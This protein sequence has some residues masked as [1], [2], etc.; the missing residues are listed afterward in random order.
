MEF[1]DFRVSFRTSGLAAEGAKRP[2]LASTRLPLLCFY[3]FPTNAV[4]CGG[5]ALTLHSS[6]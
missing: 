4:D 1:G 5:M 3:T 6:L 2:L